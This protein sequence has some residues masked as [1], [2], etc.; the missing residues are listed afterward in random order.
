M[1]MTFLP[2]IRNRWFPDQL[3]Y[4]VDERITSDGRVIKTLDSPEVRPGACG[5]SE[6]GGSNPWPSA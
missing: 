1:P 6:T 3:R 4:E 2:N 5:D